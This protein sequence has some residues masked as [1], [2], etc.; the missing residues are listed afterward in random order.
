VIGTWIEIY[1]G[2]RFYFDRWV[3]RVAAVAL[4]LVN[5]YILATRGHGIKFE[6]EFT[7]LPKSQK[8]LLLASC[9]VMILVAIAVSIYSV[10]AYHRYFYIV[11]PKGF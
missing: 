11:P 7:N 2:E 6:R 8:I 9:V 3:I 5:Y 10:S 4:Y 1:L